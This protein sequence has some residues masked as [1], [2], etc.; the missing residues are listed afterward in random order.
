MVAGIVRYSVRIA[1]TVIYN[2][3]LALKRKKKITNTIKVN[4]SILISTAIL[5]LQCTFRHCKKIPPPPV[6]PR[7]PPRFSG[8]LTNKNFNET[9]PWDKNKKTDDIADP[10]MVKDYSKK[11][12]NKILNTLQ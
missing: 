4:T 8:F 10:S 12:D 7:F 11:K 2:H 1:H 9:F 3:D 6:L 5:G